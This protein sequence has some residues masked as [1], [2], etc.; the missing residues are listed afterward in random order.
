MYTYCVTPHLSLYVLPH[1]FQRDPVVMNLE[2]RNLATRAWL[3][4]ESVTGFYTWMF[5]DNYGKKYAKEGRVLQA[6]SELRSSG[7]GWRSRYCLPVE[8]IGSSIRA[9]SVHRRAINSNRVK[10]QNE[11]TREYSVR[12]ASGL[13][14]RRGLEE[15]ARLATCQ[16]PSSAQAHHAMSDTSPTATT[17]LVVSYTP[18]P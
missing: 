2:Q 1:A 12:P 6:E 17:S 11:T 9:C 13:G 3:A 8:T 14:H 15:A 4:P 7:R 5:S 10:H 18:R 16:E